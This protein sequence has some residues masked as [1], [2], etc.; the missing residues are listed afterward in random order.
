[1]TT[2]VMM[3]PLGSSSIH[4]H[5]NGGGHRSPATS[6]SSASSPRAGAGGRAGLSSSG[7]EAIPH[8]SLHSLRSLASRRR[9]ELDT[10]LHST[11][12]HSRRSTRSAVRSV[13]SLHRTPSKTSL[14]HHHPLKPPGAGVSGP[15]PPGYATRGI[16]N[17]EDTD[18]ESSSCDEDEDI[19]DFDDDADDHSDSDDSCSTFAESTNDCVANKRYLRRGMSIEIGASCDS[20]DLSVSEFDDNIFA[21]GEDDGDPHHALAFSGSADELGELR[22][23]EEMLR[24]TG[25][26]GGS[27]K[28][29]AVEEEGNQEDE[30]PPLDDAAQQPP[31][32]QEL[33]P[34]PEESPASTASPPKSPLVSPARASPPP[35]PP[36]QN[37]PEEG[38][39]YFV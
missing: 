8:G 28:P 32:A 24:I 14:M 38:M 5:S 29:P 2:A 7:E 26:G 1:M 3:D 9:T 15:P 19:N 11:S 23:F 12:S 6:I 36:V 16:V 31:P 37:L 21:L 33:P 13:L 18:G 17:Y 34:H 27:N 39:A 35:P 25:G 20:A 30:A 22:A 4:N 10:D